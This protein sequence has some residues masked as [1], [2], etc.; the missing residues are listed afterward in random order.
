MVLVF[1]SRQCPLRLLSRNQQ[2]RAM[3]R[4]CPF[5]CPSLQKAP[6]S[7]AFVLWD[8]EPCEENAAAQPRAGLGRLASGTGQPSPCGSPGS[9][10]SP[11][12]TLPHCL[13][14]QPGP[15]RL[16]SQ[17][18]ADGMRGSPP[19]AVS[20]QPRLRLGCGE[21]PQT[22][23][24]CF[25]PLGNNRRGRVWPESS[26]RSVEPQCGWRRGG[27]LGEETLRADPTQGA[28]LTA[29]TFFPHFLS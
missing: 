3:N 10:G 6:T 5:T 21:A 11:V 12:P 7:Q 4:M 25:L 20:P 17:P 29:G 1:C 19:S 28:Q 27:G 16:R 18:T 22:G 15:R 8:W 13:G 2:R 14:I 9:R 23:S 26:P 24:F